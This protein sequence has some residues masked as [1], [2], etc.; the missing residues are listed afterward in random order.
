MAS[1]DKPGKTAIKLMC[2]YGC[3]QVF[4]ERINQAQPSTLD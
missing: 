3:V 2:I 4:V 1:I